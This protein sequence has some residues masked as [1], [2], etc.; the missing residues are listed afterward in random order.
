MIF[1]FMFFYCLQKLLVGQWHVQLVGQWHVQLVGL[2]NIYFI[3]QSLGNTSS[4][5]SECLLCFLTIEQ[6]NLFNIFCLQFRVNA[7]SAGQVRGDTYN[8]GC[9]GQTGTCII[10]IYSSSLR[11]PI[12][13]VD[14][15]SRIPTSTQVT[16]ITA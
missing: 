13:P 11:D 8:T 16:C 2:T 3:Q 6:I 10:I 1:I 15:Y 7:V 9:I 4:S 5:G 12:G 14:E